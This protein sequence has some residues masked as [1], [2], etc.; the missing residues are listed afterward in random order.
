MCRFDRRVKDLSGMRFGRLVALFDTGQRVN[1][2]V[3]WECKC[4]CGTY[5]SIPGAQ[6]TR[7]GFSKTSCRSCLRKRPVE[8]F[9]S[10]KRGVESK[11][12]AEVDHAL[13]D[14]NVERMVRA[15]VKRSMKKL[16]ARLTEMVSGAVDDR[17]SELVKTRITEKLE[18]RITGRQLRRVGGTR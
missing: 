13:D 4:D 9:A 16:D 5:V 2:N 15:H 7:V 12:K 17:I 10:E 1:G 8:R 11:I 6:L 18:G 3:V 14:G